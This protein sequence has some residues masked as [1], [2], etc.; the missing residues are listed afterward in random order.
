MSHSDYTP[1]V[2]FCGGSTIDDSLPPESLSSQTPA[3]DQ[4]ARMVLTDE[5]IAAG[6]QVESM[7]GNRLMIDAI[8]MPDG[9]VLLIN[10]AATGVSAFPTFHFRG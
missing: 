6:W 2:L 3:S 5:G 4:C 1:E 7:P 8:V 9:N 10:G